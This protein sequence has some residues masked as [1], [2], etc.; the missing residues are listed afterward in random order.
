MPQELGDAFYRQVSQRD[1]PKLYPVVLLNV[2]KLRSA[3][4]Q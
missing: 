3:L 2:P 1:V 4:P